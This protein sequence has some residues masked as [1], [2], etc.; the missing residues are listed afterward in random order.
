M[1][2][3]S[4]TQLQLVIAIPDD[5]N[6]LQ[7]AFDDAF[8]RYQGMPGTPATLTKDKLYKN[9]STNF[10]GNW[11]ERAIERHM[12]LRMQK[13]LRCK[14][15][16]QKRQAWESQ[17]GGAKR[18]MSNREVII[19][20]SSGDGLQQQSGSL[21][22][23]PD[24][25]TVAAKRELERLSSLGTYS[26]GPP[27]YSPVPPKTVVPQRPHTAF[28]PLPGPPSVVNKSE[29]KTEKPFRFAISKNAPPSVKPSPR[30]SVVD[31]NVEP[32]MIDPRNPSRTYRP[33]TS[34]SIPSKCSRYMLVSR[35]KERTNFPLPSPIEEQLLADRFPNLGMQVYRH[36]SD[37]ALRSKKVSY[38]IEYTPY[39]SCR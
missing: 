13:E 38:C 22:D 10:E 4:N 25:Y 35:P 7:N 20:N 27:R 15:A 1:V 37:I 36:H 12:L 9:D 28:V 21:T 34:R 32:K 18:M 14:S 11:Q 26:P 30:R 24:T 6:D 29:L 16:A 17:R 33:V 31:F 5:I 23:R 2:S 19:D 3:L 8:D 39:G